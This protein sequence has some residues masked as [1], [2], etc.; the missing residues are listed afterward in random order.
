LV[1]PITAL[2]CGGE[3]VFAIGTGL[4]VVLVGLIFFLLAA[5]VLVGGKAAAVLFSSAS[6][7]A[8]GSGVPGAIGASLAIPAAP[9]AKVG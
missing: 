6:V 8:A 4:V 1:L 9:L 5:T 3:G 7:A 2:G